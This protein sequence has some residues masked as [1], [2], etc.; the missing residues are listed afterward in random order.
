MFISKR[1]S[2]FGLFLAASMLIQATHAV[3]FYAE[4]GKWKCFQDVVAKNSVSQIMSQ[5]HFSLWNPNVNDCDSLL[6][7]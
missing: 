4:K 6:D 3:Y 7:S 1:L 5:V 2:P